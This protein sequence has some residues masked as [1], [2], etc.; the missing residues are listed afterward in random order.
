MDRNE[1]AVKPIHQVLLEYSLVHF[2]VRH[3]GLHVDIRNEGVA[4]VF[5]QDG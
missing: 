2:D 4:K 1:A 3:E 5:L